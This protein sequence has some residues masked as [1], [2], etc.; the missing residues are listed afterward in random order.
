MPTKGKS[1]D[2]F[3]IPQTG[4]LTQEQMVFVFQYYPQYSMNPAEI[5][6]WLY[7]EAVRTEQ[8]EKLKQQ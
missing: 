1:S 6:N 3:I 8:E 5:V 2:F 4:Q 7:S